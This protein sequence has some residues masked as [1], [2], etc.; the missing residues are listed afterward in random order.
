MSALRTSLAFTG[1][2]GL[3]ALSTACGMKGPETVP[4][5]PERTRVVIAATPEEIASVLKEDFPARYI[6]GLRKLNG[7]GGEMKN[8]QT[9]MQ[10]VP[11]DMIRVR[12]GADATRGDSFDFFY[13][14]TPEGTSI[15]GDGYVMVTG[16]VGTPGAAM[17]VQHSPSVDEEG[18]VKA[19]LLDVKVK[20]EALHIKNGSK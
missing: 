6:A 8:P 12:F 17:H 4:F 14:V 18:M 16:T 11:P 15:A 10:M 13:K 20:A 19:I 3:A 2:L 7:Q 9:S 1:L 5:A